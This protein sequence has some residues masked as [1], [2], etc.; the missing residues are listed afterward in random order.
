MPPS[1]LIAV[2]H[3]NK[4]CN[5][6]REN[7]IDGLT[8]LTLHYHQVQDLS[9]VVNVLVLCFMIFRMLVARR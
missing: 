9:V 8:V 5:A 4:N 6:V 2:S 1:A 3:L 7:R